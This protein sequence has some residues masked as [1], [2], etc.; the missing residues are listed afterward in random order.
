MSGTV[1][2][3]ITVSNVDMVFIAGKIVKW[4]R[5]GPLASASPGCAG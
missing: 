3:L 2:T 5:V 1:V 4:H